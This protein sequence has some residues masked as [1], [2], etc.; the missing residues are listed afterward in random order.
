[1]VNAVKTAGE[2]GYLDIPP[3]LSIDVSEVKNYTGRQLVII[4]TGS[5]GEPMAAL[6]RMSA[7]DH[8]QI[9][10]KPG[11]KIII[12]A[13]PIPGNEKMIS[14]VIND[15]MKLGAD[16]LYEGL[17]EVHVSGHAKREELKLMHALINPTYLMPI[18]G[19]YRH[20]KQHKDLAVSMGMDKENVFVMDI[21]DVLELTAKSAK[22]NGN[23]PS[24]QLLVDGL[25]IGDVSSVVLRDRKH[26]AEDGLII[27][28]AGVSMD[29]G[30]C[31]LI[32]GPEIITRGFVFV[33]ESEDLIEGAKAV[34]RGSLYD[35]EQKNTADWQY[36]RNRMRDDLKNHIWQK[37]KR[38]PMIFPILLEV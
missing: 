36:V 11:D 20:L 17:M 2:L 33:R 5:Q 16:V 14:K 22:K 34:V 15:L 10:I 19:E 26:L 25:G 7:S 6:S 4:T 1:M 21:G 28:A 32:S 30:Y 3:G 13:S 37:M 35:C 27:A 23:V 9:D 12:S 31:Q 24:G 29:G 38:N 18:H 8:R